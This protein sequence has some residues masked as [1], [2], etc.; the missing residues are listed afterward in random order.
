MQTSMENGEEFANTSPKA[1]SLKK[2]NFSINPS[3]YKKL[4]VNS[5]EK[6]QMN[7]SETNTN[8]I[9]KSTP[10]DGISWWLKWLGSLA[11]II[12]AILSASN[13][14]PYNM[15]SGLVC[16]TSWAVVGMMWQDRALIVM[17]IFLLGVYT[18]TLVHLWKGP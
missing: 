13:L 9:E 1:E 4:I 5:L 6:Q 8:T 16:F 18:M 7:A 10:P 15:I 2:N 11:G 12:T 17:N 3:D 14:F